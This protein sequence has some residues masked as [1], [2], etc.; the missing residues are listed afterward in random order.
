VA[1]QQATLQTN[2]PSVRPPNHS[3]DTGSRQVVPVTRNNG[4]TSFLVAS[5]TVPR[6]RFPMTE[7]N[8]PSLGWVL[9]SAQ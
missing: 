9:A 3:E 8:C 5:T 6:H 1:D 2:S 7:S 4:A